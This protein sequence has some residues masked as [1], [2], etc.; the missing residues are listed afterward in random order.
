MKRKNF[1]FGIIGTGVIAHF[2]AKAI[3][4]IE[5]AKLI[6][7][8]NINKQKADLFAGTHNCIAYATLDE[9]L[10]NPEIDI[11]C[12]CTPSG[13]HL[14]PALK[15]IE[16]KKHCIIEKPLEVTLERCDEIINAAE[17]ASV[18]VGVIFPSRFAE[19]NQLLK[20]ALDQNRFGDLVLGDAYVKWSRSAEYYKSAAWRGTWKHDGGG[21]VMNQGIHS[22]DL[23]QWFMGPVKSVQAF[24]AN[25][26]H[27]DI[28]VE[29]TLVAILKFA[30]G[31]VGTI[32]CSTA[33]FPG[34]AKR[35]EI[36][37]TSGTAVVEENSLVK[38][39]FQNQSGED[40]L[41]RVKHM[42]ADAGGGGASNPT[43]ISFTGHQ[44][45]IEDMLHAIETGEKPFVDGWEGRKSVEIVLA[46]YESAK[47]WSQVNIA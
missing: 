43:G 42:P 44:R 46:M 16:Q 3:V 19:V 18:K 27:R 13:L 28:E 40:E 26:R 45:Q 14:E 32:E 11:V 20:N 6:G 22:V 33:V 34:S 21:A 41:F 10:R 25:I 36:L 12:I 30:N 29:D 31:A 15:A 39:E 35:I 2:H 7:V 37:G 24:A 23:L 5:N 8:F 38:W 4:E 17:K 47:T 9:M 1:G